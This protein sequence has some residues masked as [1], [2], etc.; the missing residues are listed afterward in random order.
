MEH[1][2]HD[3][4]MEKGEQTRTRI[5][6]AAITVIAENG[7]KEVSA[8]KLANATGVSKSNIFHH[9]KSV[10]EILM[11]VLYI[12]FDDL[13]APMSQKHGSLEEFLNAMGQSVFH[14]PKEYLKIFKAFFS[15]Y[16]EGMFNSKYQKVLADCTS[17]I[18][19]IICKQL[20]EL[21]PGS[22]TQE[23]C[24][25]VATLLLSM[26]D[27]MGLHYLLKEEGDHFEQA[28]RLQVQLLCRH[29]LEHN[30]PV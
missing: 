21:T 5:L 8:A 29:L 11:G 24:Q 6:N 19:D 14:V 12:I 7:I 17:Q 25:S 4:R 18:T 15:F 3:K 16:H 2:V 1:K 27:G 10:D 20:T 13:L 23:A 28:W 30:Y 9:F 22:V 26:I